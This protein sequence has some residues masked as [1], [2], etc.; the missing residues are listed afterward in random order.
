MLALKGVPRVL[1]VERLD[2]PFDQR[3]IFAIMF[4]MAAGAFL[5]GTRRDVV[6]RM[7]ATSRRKARRDFRVTFEALQ[8]SLSAEFVTAGTIRR[9]IQRLVRT[10]KRSGRNLRGGWELQQNE[11]KKQTDEENGSL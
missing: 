10:G 1:V 8:R 3:E 5:T 6:G 9:S 4:G 7:Q 11:Q 2:V